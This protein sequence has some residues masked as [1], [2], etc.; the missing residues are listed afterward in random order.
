MMKYWL[1]LLFSVHLFAD[2][3]S[4]NGTINFD[5]NSDASA[6]LVLNSTGLGVG[7]IPTANLHVMGNTIVSESL[8]IGEV[9]VSTLNI[10]GTIGFGIETLSSNITLGDDSFIS[11]NSS[12]DNVLVTLPYAGNVSGRFYTIT[13]T[14]QSNSVWISGGANLIDTRFIVELSDG[15]YGSVEMISDGRQWYT[16]GSKSLQSTVAGTNL[17]GWWS[18]DDTSGN[19][20]NDLSVSELSGTLYEGLEFS[21]NSVVGVDG[22]GLSFDGIDDYVDLG[23]GAGDLIEGERFSVSFWFR[24]DGAIV[25]ND[26]L[27][28]KDQNGPYAYS[29]RFNSSF[30]LQFMM[31]N[32]SLNSGFVP[33]EG[34]WYHVVTR[35]DSSIGRSLFVN[36]NLIVD[37]S[38]TTLVTS[39]D[40]HLYLGFDHTVANSRHPQ[41]SLDDLR[42]YSKSLTAHEIKLIYEETL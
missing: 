24:I 6:E 10:N 25:N 26:G 11:I 40:D 37:D 35:F 22:T 29:V 31:N 34:T 23:E 5:S 1:F 28:S 30:E 3:K 8:S 13:K 15:L 16:L 19:T 39:D 7:I 4:T 42:I 17:T 9:G 20:L 18:F 27:I 36:G 2:I 41:M 33:V 32:S 12:N 21:S 14:V 38:Y